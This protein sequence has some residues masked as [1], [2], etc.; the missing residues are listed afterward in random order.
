[1][2]HHRTPYARAGAPGAPSLSRVRVVL[3]RTRNPHNL[4]AAARALRCAGI[5]RW[6]LVDPLCDTD[7]PEATRVAVRAEGLLQLARVENTLADAVQGC[8]LTL[9]ATA[10]PR[11]G[12]PGI[13]PKEAARRMIASPGE[14]AIVF[15]DEQNGLHADEVEQLDQI[16]TMHSAPEQPSWNLAQAVAIYAHE[17]RGAAI[18][19]EE[20]PS[21]ERAAD[22]ARMAAVSRALGSAL[23]A[24]DRPRT[25]HRLFPA[26]ERARLSAREALV[27]VAVL[28]RIRRAFAA[29]DEK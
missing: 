13:A 9:A 19:A 22:P 20:R 12:R 10:R 1:M 5:T 11:F 18:E 4:G 2:A 15:G 16:T 24:L 14:T 27:W 25:Q 23:H 3:M 29:R 17:L 8:S 21:E 28:E 7:D 6:T 26:L